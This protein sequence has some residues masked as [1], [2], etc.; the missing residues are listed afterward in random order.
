MGVTTV[1]YTD[2]ARDGMLCVPNLPALR[3]MIATGLRVIASGGISCLDDLRAL[4]KIPGVDGA[5]VGMALYTGAI[6]LRE[7]VGVGDREISDQGG[8][9]PD[10]LI[11]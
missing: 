10:S 6:A 3:Q 1:V 5:I 11:P 4:A 2:I 7:A 8:T 9:T